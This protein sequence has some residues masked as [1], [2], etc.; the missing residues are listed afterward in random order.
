MFSEAFKKS[1]SLIFI[2]HYRRVVERQGPLPTSICLIRSC[3]PASQPLQCWPE[4][5]ELPRKSRAYKR[6][7]QLKDVYLRSSTAD[8]GEEGVKAH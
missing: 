1:F 6:L 8:D 7:E 4:R 3:Q 2:N 5:V